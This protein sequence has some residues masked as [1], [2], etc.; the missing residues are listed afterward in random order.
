MKTKRFRDLLVWQRSMR[1]AEEIYVI[2]RGFPKEELFW[3]SN[4][5]RRAAVSVPSNIAEGFGRD[6]DRG[7]AVFLAQARGSLYELETQLELARNLGLID[8][9]RAAPLLADAAEVGRM[10]HGLR[11]ALQRNVPTS[12]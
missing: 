8:A 10:L 4:Q 5:M 11:S 1:L 2:A 7:F 6:S 12:E 9:Q 3:L